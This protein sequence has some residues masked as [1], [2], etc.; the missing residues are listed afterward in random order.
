M[1]G[2]RQVVINR[3]WHADSMHLVVHPLCRLRN[4]VC[5]I[6]RVVATD[7]EQRP[8]VVFTQNIYNPLKVLILEFVAACPE[9]C[10]RRI[11][12]PLPH[13]CRLTPQVDHILFQQTLDAVP[14]PINTIDARVG[15]RS[16][17][18]PNQA[19]IDNGSCT[20][21]LPNYQVVTYC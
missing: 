11:Q 4:A 7:V 21:R 13:V 14:H 16:L 10:R 12:Q 1:I 8:D 19:G 18:S 20:A 2:K 6:G 17:D 9:R 5:S 15:H 3:L